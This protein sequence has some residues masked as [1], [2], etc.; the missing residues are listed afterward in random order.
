MLWNTARVATE[1]RG[2]ESGDVA[3]HGGLHS[4]SAAPRG[5]GD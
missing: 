4:W 1:G 3:A 2:L 5:V